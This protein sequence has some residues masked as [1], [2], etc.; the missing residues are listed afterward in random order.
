[1]LTTTLILFRGHDCSFST[2]NTSSSLFVWL[3]ES[4]QW[5]WWWWWWTVLCTYSVD[6]SLILLLHLFEWNVVSIQSGQNAVVGLT[7]MH[8]YT[9]A[10]NPKEGGGKTVS[11]PTKTRVTL[12]LRPSLGSLRMNAFARLGRK[13]GR[14][15]GMKEWQNHI[16]FS[17]LVG[18]I[19]GFGPSLLERRYKV[20]R[21]QTERGERK[22]MWALCYHC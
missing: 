2:F 21:S 4:G 14:K 1:M 22:V 20:D 8:T 10:Q 13:E 15:E 19:G 7:F 6:H 11:K 18:W 12:V 16:T 17:G 5:W 3:Q 9:C